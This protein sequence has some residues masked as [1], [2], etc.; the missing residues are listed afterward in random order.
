MTVVFE[1][2][3]EVPKNFTGTCYIKVWKCLEHLVNGRPH[4]EDGPAIQYDTGD[5]LW[6][7]NGLYHRLDGP[8]WK[9]REHHTYYI[10]NREYTEEEFWN[11]PEVIR[12]KLNKILQGI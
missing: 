12:N 6:F 8:A 4:C 11:Q 7:Q 10:K 2:K 5:Y 3:K 9:C 1:T